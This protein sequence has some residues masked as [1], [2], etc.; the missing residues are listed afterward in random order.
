M[1][2]LCHPYRFHHENR[3]EEATLFLNFATLL[4]GLVFEQLPE[5]AS[6]TSVP[7]TDILVF[8]VRL[9]AHIGPS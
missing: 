8:A 2:F 6:K 5:I 9:L 7:I 4:A 1:Q 3:M